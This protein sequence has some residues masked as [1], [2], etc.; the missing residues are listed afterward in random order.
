MIS[1]R[2]FFQVNNGKDRREKNV[3]QDQPDAK[4]ARPGFA[5]VRA[6]GYTGVM[7]QAEPI[8]PQIPVSEEMRAEI[9]GALAEID[10][11]QMAIIARM[12][13]AQRMEMGF[14][15]S[16]SVLRIAVDRLR[17]LR[18][19]LS[20]AEANREFLA[21]YYALEAKYNARRRA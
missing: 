14:A 18:P 8:P 5:P 15:M 16:N 1:E 2:V 7:D 9:R 6:R 17:Q 4:R 21:R 13:P 20:E 3:K 19:E 10:P 11:A 12:T